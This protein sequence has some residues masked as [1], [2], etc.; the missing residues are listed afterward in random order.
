M[1]QSAENQVSHWRD[2]ERGRQ[3]P[4]ESAGLTLHELETY[5]AIEI[6]ESYHQ[7]IHRSLQRAPIAVW[8]EFIGAE[9]ERRRMANVR[10]PPLA[11]STNF[12]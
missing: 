7:R 11:P 4:A 3:D 12:S 8:R 2:T 10:R 1:L 5:F 9:T 6:A